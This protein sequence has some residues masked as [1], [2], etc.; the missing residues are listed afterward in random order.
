MKKILLLVSL[1]T[2]LFASAQTQD[3]L[4][5]WKAGVLVHKQSIKPEAGQPSAVSEKRARQHAPPRVAR[6]AMR[7]KRSDS[8]PGGQK[9]HSS[10]TDI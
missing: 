8:S 10:Q 4:F 3:S 7:M 9:P 2:V 1:F 6:V 5:V